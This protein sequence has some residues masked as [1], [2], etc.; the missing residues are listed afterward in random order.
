[1]FLRE[2]KINDEKIGR[3]IE[4][5]YGSFI[6]CGFLESFCRLFEWGF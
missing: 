1:M 2:I 5:G 6:F 4:D 3:K